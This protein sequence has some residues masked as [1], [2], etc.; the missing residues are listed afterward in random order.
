M[1]RYVVIPWD[2]ALG[3]SVMESHEYSGLVSAA[4]VIHTIPARAAFCRL[5]SS[6]QSGLYHRH[7]Q[8]AP[9]AKVSDGFSSAGKARFVDADGGKVCM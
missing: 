6:F 7:D 9:V 4:D 1:A 8:E 2:R 3:L 5:R